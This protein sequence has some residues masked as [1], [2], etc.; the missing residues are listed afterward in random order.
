M[1]FSIV[2]PLYNEERNIIRLNS[3][4]V[5]SIDTILQSNEYKF[6]IIF[7]DDGSTDNTL[8]ELK[9]IKNHI[10]TVIIQN[11]R[12][13]SQSKSILNG[14]EI[15]GFQNIILM[16]GDLQNDPKDIIELVN[17]YS[18]QTDVIIHGNRKNRSDPFFS[19]IIPSKIA[20]YL[21]RK[22]TNS[23][24]QDHGCS[25]KIFKKEIIQTENFFG[26]FHRLF[27]AQINKNLKII[28]VN[29][30]HRPRI[31]GKSNY[32]FE[33]ILRVMIDLIFIRFVN[34]QRSYF[35]NLGILGLFSFFSSFISFVYM[36]ILKIFDNKSFI[37]TPLPTLVVFFALCG[38][39]FFS[40][41][42]MIET[43]KKSFLENSNKIKLYKK[44]N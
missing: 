8:D 16:D 9:K 6:E 21:V 23:K 10:K 34:N 38:L 32:G 24:I 35:Y 39:I 18:K 29:V 20:N 44:I 7:V 27:A 1:D 42:L 14:I 2:I 22:F 19:K 40:I 3:E 37:E 30:N 13:L 17:L 28:E 33:R 12:N 43:I 5:K 15:A 25:L 36:I 26:D 11:I 4:I 31:H 41:T